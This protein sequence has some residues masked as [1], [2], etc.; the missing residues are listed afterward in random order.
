MEA[1]KAVIA[2]PGPFSITRHFE[3]EKLSG[4]TGFWDFRIPGFQDPGISASW[5]CNH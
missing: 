3:T 4:I 2:I 1:L 5:D